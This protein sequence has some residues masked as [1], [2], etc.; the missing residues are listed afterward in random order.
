MQAD[1]IT[2]I[3]TTWVMKFINSQIIFEGLQSTLDAYAYS[4]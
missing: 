2:Q 3:P 1:G 4:L